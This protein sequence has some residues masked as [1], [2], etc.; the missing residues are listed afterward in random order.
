MGVMKKNISLYAA[1]CLLL[2]LIEAAVLIASFTF[3]AT[4]AKIIALLLLAS[5]CYDNILIG[6][7]AQIDKVTLIRLSYVRWIA[8]WVLVP[9][10]LIPTITLAQRVH[11]LNNGW[12]LP[13]AYASAV[14]LGFYDLCK[15]LLDDRL[16]FKPVHFAGTVRLVS[17]N[18]SGPPLITIFVNIVLF[19]VSI[20]IR[21]N[22]GDSSLLF[23]SIAALVGNSVPSSFAG[24]LPGSLGEAM[25]FFSVLRANTAV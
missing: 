6:L 20:L 5:G 22:S 10:L 8:H 4:S 21:R 25:L 3:P 11:I 13:F 19:T 9:W 16:T 7:G 17:E 1:G 24:S 12:A 23:G 14:L 18:E 15:G 2:A